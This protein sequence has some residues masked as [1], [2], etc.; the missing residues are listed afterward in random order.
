MKINYANR[1]LSTAIFVALTISASKTLA[2]DID[3]KDY[4][5]APEGTNLALLYLQYAD[6][7]R[8]YDDGNRVA[9]DNRL[10]SQIGIFRAVHF[11]K[12]GDMTV[13]PQILIPYGK[14]EGKGDLSDALGSETDFA[15]PILAATFWVQEDHKSGEYTGIT[16]YIIPPIGSYDNERPLNLGNN[17]WE[18]VLQGAHTRKL[19][20]KL[21]LDLSLDMTHYG[22]NDEF[23]PDKQTQ[24]RDVFWQMQGFLTYDVTPT[25]DLRL[26][27]SHS[28][29]GE[30]EVD[31]VRQDDRIQRT[32]YEV[33]GSF[34]VT[35]TF[36]V[37]GTYGGDIE[38]ENSFSE[39]DRVNVRLL[40]VF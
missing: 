27:L 1:I 38:N 15:D 24:R 40:K 31:S 13:D 16:P 32:K 21:W 25:A 5:P 11:M 26:K 22:K 39:S 6:S 2:L 20:N 28:L 34:F 36:Q 30:T 3:A 10:E 14:V 37:L 12:I 7:D 18:F 33:G 29:G 9:G 35:D 8:L 17:R 19:T 4:V 23:G